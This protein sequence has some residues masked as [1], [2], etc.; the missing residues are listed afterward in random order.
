M[1][2]V[3]VYAQKIQ[4]IDRASLE[5]AITPVLRA[6]GVESVEISY[7]MERTGWILRVIVESLSSDAPAPAADVEGPDAEGT[8]GI[9][10]GLL[11]EI[12][13]DLSATLDV[14]EVIP[15]R[16]SLEVSSPGLDR[17]LRSPRDYRRVLGQVAKVHLARPAPD[18]QRVLRGRVLEVVGDESVRVEVDGKP[19]TTRF[20][21]VERA[22]LIFELPTNPKG[23]R[24]KPGKHQ[25]H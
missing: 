19:I 18:G 20:D 7:M 11:T 16:Y 8:H 12:S 1:E 9:H 2:I 21:D 13:R 15:H 22:N 4:G 3:Q 14:S 5:A 17:P 23:G 24:P 10:L 6:H 25:R